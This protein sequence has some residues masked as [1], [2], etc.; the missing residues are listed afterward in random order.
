MR[1]ASG[2]H[3]GTTAAEGH[4]P[5]QDRRSPRWVASLTALPRHL[6][7]RLGPA[8]LLCNCRVQT[9]STLLVC[10]EL[11]HAWTEN[12]RRMGWPL[13]SRRCWQSACSGEYSG[14]R[15]LVSTKLKPG[16]GDGARH[17][18]AFRPRSVLWTAQG[19]SSDNST[20]HQTCEPRRV[21]CLS[22]SLQLESGTL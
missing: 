17:Q 16:T 11:G 2:C 19:T 1:R 8:T 10:R 5:Q 3:Q 15:W 14:K 13:H 6:K 4:A 18:S 22:I 9:R 20:M 21:S 12:L 7:M